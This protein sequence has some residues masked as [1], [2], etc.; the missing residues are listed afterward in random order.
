VA[1]S[2]AFLRWLCEVPGIAEWTAQWVAVRALREPDAFPSADRH[3]AD[4][5]NLVSSSEL[6]KY[7]LA[8]RPWRAYAAMYLWTFAGEIQKRENGC[9]PSARKKGV[10]GEIGFHRRIPARLRHVS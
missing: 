3:F 7:S 10:G 2:D 8:W 4:T 5:L 6:E 9:E 1:D